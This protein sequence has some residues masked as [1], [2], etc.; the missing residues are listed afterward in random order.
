M[1]VQ[2]LTTVA[3]DRFAPGRRL[4]DA[5]DVLADGVGAVEGGVALGGCAAEVARLAVG[6]VAS[7][8]T[9]G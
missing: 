6:L 4:A 9:T 1:R 7:R 3:A 8:E 5:A 2:S